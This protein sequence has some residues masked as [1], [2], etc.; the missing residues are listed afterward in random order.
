M[1]S[2]WWSGIAC[3]AFTLIS[4]EVRGGEVRGHTDDILVG[5]SYFAGWW[6]PLPNKWTILGQDWRVRYPARVP[7]LGEYK[8]QATMDREIAAAADHGVDFFIILWYPLTAAHEGGNAPLL[9]RAVREFMASPRA[10]RMKFMIEYCNHPPFIARSDSEWKNEWFELLR[11]ALV[12]PSYLRIDGQPVIKIHSGHHL[13]QACDGNLDR[14]KERLDSVRALAREIGADQPLM[15]A[16]VG[17][18]E[19][20]AEGHW[21]ADLFDFTATYMDVPPDELRDEDYPFSRLADFTHEGR[22]VHAQDAVPS[23]PYVPAGW[24]PS[25]RGDPRARYQLPTKEQ[26]GEML[27]QVEFDLNQHTTFGLPG[28]K[29]FTIYAWNEYGEGG[30]V[31]PTRGEGYMKLR[32]IRRVFGRPRE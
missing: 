8:N 25:P 21:A 1:W 23:M 10:H 15:G 19:P 6:E 17:S 12:H 27:R 28:A 29:A 11:A 16:G 2:L 7:L 14:V 5:I 31:A 20:I 22:M 18:R 32:E 9:N 3:C 13:I 24:N 26:W 4:P 30:F